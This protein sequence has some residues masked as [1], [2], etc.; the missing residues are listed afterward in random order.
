MRLIDGFIF[1][2]CGFKGEFEKG[3]FP[4][5]PEHPSRAGC[6]VSKSTWEQIQGQVGA[7]KVKIQAF[8]FWNLNKC[9]K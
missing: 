3:I 1:P 5:G 4:Q 8:F 9:S 7:R 6:W 2:A